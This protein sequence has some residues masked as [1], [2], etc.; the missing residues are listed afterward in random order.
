MTAHV[1]SYAATSIVLVTRNSGLILSPANPATAAGDAL[2]MTVTR[3]ST[4]NVSPIEVHLT[5]DDPLTL[6]TPSTVTIPSG[7]QSANFSVIG[8]APGGATIHA[9]AIGV[10]DNT[11]SYSSVTVNNPALSLLSEP[12]DEHRGR[13]AGDHHQPAV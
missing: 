1:G 7:Q 5:A 6:F 2:P 10:E 3:T 9:T 11:N 13:G 8:L 4:T 12:R